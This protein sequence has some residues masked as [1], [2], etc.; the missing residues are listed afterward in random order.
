V[1][2]LVAVLLALCW[3][4]PTHL[5]WLKRAALAGALAVGHATAF[6]V[7]Q[8]VFHALLVRSAVLGPGDPVLVPAVAG[9]VMLAGYVGGLTVCA[10]YLL[11][12][13]WFGANHNEL[14]AAMRL[15]THKCFLRLRVAPNGTLTVFPLKVE[16][17]PR[18]RRPG[19]RLAAGAL[20]DYRVAPQLIE[21]PVTVRPRG[22]LG[23]PA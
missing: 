19:R 21:E 7:A 14:F 4:L 20:R 13:S 9:W 18:V 23:R 5:P 10:W 17:P 8:V 6:F 1:W 3:S 11:V 22:S 16:R 15:A 12:A 2:L